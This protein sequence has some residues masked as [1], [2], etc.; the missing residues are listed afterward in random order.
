MHPQP[1]SEG[2]PLWSAR[3]LSRIVKDREADAFGSEDL[4]MGSKL[5]R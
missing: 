5:E 1:V 4:A 2:N 3:L